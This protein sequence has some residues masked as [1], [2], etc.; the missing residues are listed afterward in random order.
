LG[1]LV[2][3]LFL[4][5]DFILGDI[6]ALQAI[7]WHT[8]WAVLKQLPS[9]LFVCRREGG[10]FLEHGKA[11][12]AERVTGTAYFQGMALI[13]E[14]RGLIV[15]LKPV[16]TKDWTLAWNQLSNGEDHIRFMGLDVFNPQRRTLEVI[17]Q[18]MEDARDEAEKKLEMERE[19]FE[20]SGGIKSGTCPP[21]AFLKRR[22]SEISEFL[23]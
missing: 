22:D 7:A 13:C 1:F 20:A 21:G 9:R 14:L 15:Q 5:L 19:K 11:H 12:I 18:Q 3:L 8:N 17:H 16:D 2:I 10:A 4:M 23:H 6:R